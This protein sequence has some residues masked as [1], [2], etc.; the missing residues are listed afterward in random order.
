MDKQPIQDSTVLGDKVH[1]T[2]EELAT[3]RALSEEELLVEKKLLFRI[4]SRI[5]PMVVLVYLMNYIDRY[6]P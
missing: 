6:V 1:V 2:H 4:D 3:L 5:M